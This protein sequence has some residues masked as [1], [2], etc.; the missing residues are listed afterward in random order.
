[1]LLSGGLEILP[2]SSVH[3]TRPPAGKKSTPAPHGGRRYLFRRGLYEIRLLC[4]VGSV[5]F[6]PER[7]VNVRGGGREGDVA[8]GDHVSGVDV[9]AAGGETVVDGIDHERIVDADGKVWTVDFSG[10][11]TTFG[12]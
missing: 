9:I 4:P 2:L 5:A 8:A 7:P 10:L 3:S 1:M 12:T 11:R 6:Q